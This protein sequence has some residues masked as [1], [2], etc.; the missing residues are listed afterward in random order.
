MNVQGRWSGDADIPL[1][2][3]GHEQA[4]QT[5][6]SLKA[7]GLKFDLIISSPLER[8]LDTA[9]HIAKELGYPP[10]KILVNELL[11]ERHFGKLEGTPYRWYITL[12]Y[13]LNEASVD[14]YDSE[15]F[16]EVK[17][18]ATKAAV[19]LNSL[20]AET[21]LIVS[22]GAFGRS[23]YA[24]FHPLRRRKLRYKNAKIMRFV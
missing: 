15:P 9:K 11:K 14:K 23:L 4:I 2:A 20:E 18:R 16:T 24:A 19:Y 17:Q 7:Q 22:H 21:I 1:T 10:D 6:K 12:P 13:V 3:K 5:G 8:A